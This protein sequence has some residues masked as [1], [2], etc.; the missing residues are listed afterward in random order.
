MLHTRLTRLL[1]IDHPIIQAGMGSVAGPEL[2]AAVSEAGGLGTLATI[3][4]PPAQV[5]A[6]I[7]RTRD[8][9]G[10][11]FALNLVTFETAPF[12]DENLDVALQ[13]KAGIVTLSFGDF[14]P[15]LRR[16]KDAGATVIVQVQDAAQARAAVAGHADAII[17]QGSEAGGHTGRRGTLSFGAQVLD[18]AEGTPV[19]I[20]GG[21]AN[22]R[23]LAAALAMGADG[24]V[25]G[26]RFKLSEE[27]T[28]RPDHKEAIIAS[29]GDDTIADLANDAA[30]PFTWPSNVVGRVIR[31][32][33]AERWAGHA[34]ELR[35]LASRYPEPLGLLTDTALDPPV[36][37]NWGGQ[38]A[39]M[40]SAVRPAAEIVRDTVHQAEE[41]LTAVRGTLGA[42][43]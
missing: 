1:D 10:R 19:I 34:G 15:A 20:A 33:F 28:A 35:E 43:A 13:E 30:Y 40:M 16:F 7:A 22:G 42:Q 37:L 8:L 23:G 9:T 2:V 32:P 26:T 38:S 36:D 29:D 11:P 24:V 18:I 25:M 5:G 4:L 41:L 27:S 21:V 12:R 3:G 39:A 6:L 17:A 31:T 14:S